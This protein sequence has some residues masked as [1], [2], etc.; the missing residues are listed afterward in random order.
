M[1]KKNKIF[2]IV[3]W[4]KSGN[5]LLRA[6]IASLFF[7]EEGKLQLSQI[8]FIEKHFKKEMNNLKYL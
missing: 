3:S 8:K 1:I 5:T 2:W 6:I 4:P 7:T